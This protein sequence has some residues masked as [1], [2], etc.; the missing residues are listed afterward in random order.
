[1][2]IQL[3]EKYPAVTADE[4]FMKIYRTLYDYV[5]SKAPL[6]NRGD[7]LDWYVVVEQEATE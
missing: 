1:M 7:I 4:N 5:S 6:P 3:L 2:L